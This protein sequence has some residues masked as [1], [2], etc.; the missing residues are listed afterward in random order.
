MDEWPPHASLAKQL[1]TFLTI[2]GNELLISC[3][4][5]GMLLLIIWLFKRTSHPR[6]LIPLSSSLGAILCPLPIIIY[7][8][9]KFPGWQSDFVVFVLGIKVCI[10][11]IATLVIVGVFWAVRRISNKAHTLT[12]DSVASCFVLLASSGMYLWQVVDNI[13]NDPGPL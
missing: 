1:L 6:H 12:S 11:F 10:A 2:F 4:I 9:W 8:K 13:L 7:I 3:L 5:F